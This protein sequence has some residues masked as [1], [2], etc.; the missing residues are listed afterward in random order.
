MLNVNMLIIL[1]LFLFYFIESLQYYY[2]Y[3]S[4]K[5]VLHYKTIWWKRMYDLT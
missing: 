4:I 5:K 1:V 2:T 3:L